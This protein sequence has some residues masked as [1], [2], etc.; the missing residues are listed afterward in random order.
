MALITCHECGHEI[1]DT[2]KV[3]PSCGCKTLHSKTTKR[4]RMRVAIICFFLIFVFVLGYHINEEQ[5]RIDAA[6]EAM[7]RDNEVANRPE[8]YDTAIFRISNILTF[9]KNLSNDDAQILQHALYE[10]N[11]DKESG[12]PYSQS[13]FYTNFSKKYNIYF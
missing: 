6:V 13:D 8:D 9:R 11:R 2:A 3:C 12:V 5:K 1:S 10:L 4:K 7:I